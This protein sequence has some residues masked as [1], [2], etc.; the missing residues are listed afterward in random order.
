[1]KYPCKRY[2]NIHKFEIHSFREQK[3]RT[4]KLTVRVRCGGRNLAFPGHTLHS[5]DRRKWEN[6]RQGLDER[7][8]EADHDLELAEGRV[9]VVETSQEQNLFS[10]E[11]VPVVRKPSELDVVGTVGE[12][13]PGG[14]MESKS[15]GEFFC[16]ATGQWLAGFR[17]KDLVPD[18]FSLLGNIVVHDLFGDA[19][20]VVDFAINGLC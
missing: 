5:P 1:M 9:V 2:K 17:G 8:E 14:M 3:L 19:D 7:L 10:R 12:F 13:G 18:G 16:H 11:Q 4:T 20:L 15:V 6:D